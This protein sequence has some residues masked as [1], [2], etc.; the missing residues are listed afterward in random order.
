MSDLEKKNIDLRLAALGPV[1]HGIAAMERQLLGL[2]VP[3]E[4]LARI[5]LNHAASIIALIEPPIARAQVMQKLIGNFPEA[6]RL[7]NLAAS[8]TEGGV[9]LPKA[10]LMEA[11]PG[12]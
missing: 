5:M 4:T 12:G 10:Q 6:V 8:K 11:A 7:A 3:H 2:G 9:I 1:D